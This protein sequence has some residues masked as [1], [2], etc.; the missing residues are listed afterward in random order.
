MSA[1]LYELAAQYRQ[2]ESLEASEEIPVEVIRDTLDGLEG[3]IR[4]KCT[5]VSLFSRNLESVATSIEQAAG[6]MLARAEVLRKRAASLD[7]Y[8]LVHMQACGITKIES[9][10]FTISRKANPPAVIVDHEGSIPER[11]WRQPE[12]PPLPAKVIDKKAIAAAMKAGEEVP[13]CHSLSG[14]RIEIK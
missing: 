11:F 7:A 14:E 8:M 2:L 12:Q 13:G 3:D 9:P 6:K 4:E 1:R 10:W 5:Q